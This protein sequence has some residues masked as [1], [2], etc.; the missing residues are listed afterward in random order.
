MIGEANP[1]GPLF[2][3]SISGPDVLG[4][5]KGTDK[6]GLVAKDMGNWKSVYVATVGLPPW[7][8]RNIAKYAGVHIYCDTDDAV[9]TDGNLIA[10][11]AQSDGKKRIRLRSKKNVYDLFR[12]TSVAKNVATFEVEMAAG[13]T[14]A[15]RLD[16]AE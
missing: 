1:Q 8:L 4:R 11:H 9:Y 2:H 13:A 7:L 5:I 3:V 16:E 14:E 12:K 6:A 15:F 10:I